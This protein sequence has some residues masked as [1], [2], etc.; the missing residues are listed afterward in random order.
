M[1]TVAH[2]LFVDIMLKFGFPRILHTDSGME[3]K[4]KLIEDFSQ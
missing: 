4:S 2:H 1:M 3:F